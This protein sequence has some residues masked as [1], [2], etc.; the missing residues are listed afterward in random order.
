[1]TVEDVVSKLNDPC[2]NQLL[3]FKELCKAG[4]VRFDT[5]N[6]E[7]AALLGR[8]IQM[9]QESLSGGTDLRKGNKKSLYFMIL[10]HLC[11]WEKRGQ[12]HG[13]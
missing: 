10:M 6:P 11:S 2:L 8:M 12:R 7:H 3:F 4:V 9:M 5:D 13:K 1:M